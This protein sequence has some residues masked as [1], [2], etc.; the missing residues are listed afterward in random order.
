MSPVALITGSSRG[1]GRGIALCLAQAGYD[2]LVNYAGNQQAA[3]ETAEAVAKHGQRAEIC[4]ADIASETDGQRL[5]DFTLTSFGRLDLLVNNAGIA[6]PVRADILEASSAS[7]DQVM[8]TNLKGPYF[9]T[10]YAANKMIDLQKEGT[11]ETP[12]IVIIT[13]ISAYT[14]SIARGEYCVSKA[15][16]SMMTRL[17]ADRL[18][19]YSIP[20]NE[21]QPGIIQ[22]DMTGPVKEKY[23]KLIA[24][25]LTPI[26]RWGQPDDIGKAVVAIALGY[27]DFTT[28]AAIPVDGGFHLH[29]L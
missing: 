18:A 8:A 25:G 7:Y 1:I 22:T 9:L 24:D 14:S 2:I 23:D 26:R 6:P 27:F 17:F 4:Q 12:R 10:Q 19:Q 13:S 29:R 3:H 5:V 20:V 28:G 11:V 15:G 16:L 21:I